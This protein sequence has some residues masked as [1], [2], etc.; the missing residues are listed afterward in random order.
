[1]TAVPAPARPVTVRQGPL[2]AGAPGDSSL[3]I[4]RVGRAQT[5]ES[6]GMGMGHSESDVGVC[7]GAPGPGA[8]GPDFR[9]LA[10]AWLGGG[11]GV[12]ASGRKAGRPGPSSA[13]AATATVSPEPRPPAGVSA[14]PPSLGAHCLADVLAGKVH[15]GYSWRLIVVS[16]QLRTRRF[17]TPALEIQHSQQPEMTTDRSHIEASLAVHEGVLAGLA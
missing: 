2:P 11:P 16:R 15:R 12:L 3:S 1:M 14:D 8:A 5:T 10:V 4:S 6:P 7:T 13:P 17:C 9:L